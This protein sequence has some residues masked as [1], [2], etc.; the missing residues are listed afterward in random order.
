MIS[1]S[2]LL[3]HAQ[4]KEMPKTKVA[5]YFMPSPERQIRAI[6]DKSSQDKASKERAAET[7]EKK[8]ANQYTESTKDLATGISKDV[9]RTFEKSTKEIVGSLRSQQEQ[10]HKQGTLLKDILGQLDKT[11]RYQ[12]DRDNHVKP[13]IQDASWSDGGTNLPSALRKETPITGP[14]LFDGFGGFNG[15]GG[16]GGGRSGKRGGKNTRKPNVPMPIPTGGKQDKGNK[17]GEKGRGGNKGS[18]RN[19]SGKYSGPLP[20]PTAGTNDRDKT[21]KPTPSPGKVVKTPDGRYRDIKTGKFVK[22]PVSSWS[23]LRKVAAGALRAPGGIFGKG[24]ALAGGLFAAYELNDMFVDSNNEQRDK[25]YEKDIPESTTDGKYNESDIDLSASV[26]GVEPTN[27]A[28]PSPNLDQDINLP[29]VGDISKEKAAVGAAGAGLAGAALLAR[30]QSKPETITNNT[31]TNNNNSIKEIVTSKEAEKARRKELKTAYK[32]LDKTGT[33]VS[34]TDVINKVQEMQKQSPASKPKVGPKVTSTKPIPKTSGKLVPGIGGALT[35][36]MAAPD[37]YDTLTDDEV[38]TKDKANVVSQTAGGIAG[39][40]LGA[41]AGAAIG[42][43]IVPVVGTAIGGVAGGIIGGIAG[44]NVAGSAADF[45]SDKLDE[46]DLSDSIGKAVAVPMSLFSDDAKRAL[47]SDMDKTTTEV[48]KSVSDIKDTASEKLK[49]FDMSEI[50][51]GVVESVGNAASGLHTAFSSG[52]SFFGGSSSSS[53]PTPVSSQHVPAQLSASSVVGLKNRDV[54]LKQM[55]TAGIKDPKERAMFLA[56]MD[57]ESGG[58]RSME[59]SFNY[60]D[61]DRLRQVSSKARDMSQDELNSVVSKGPEAVAEMMYGGRMGNTEQ[62]DAYKYRGRGMIQ[63]TGKDNYAK[64]GNALGIDL[65]NNPDLAANPEVAAQIATWYWKD[66]GIADNAQQGDVK[67]VTKT[68][69][70]GYNGLDD[71]ESKYE[72]YLAMNLQS[73][74]NTT[75]S[76]TSS[77]YVAKAPAMDDDF[78]ANVN[79]ISSKGTHGLNVPVSQG[80]AGSPTSVAVSTSASTP[81]K[82]AQQSIAYG[83]ANAASV[84]AASP[85]VQSAYDFPTKLGET[86]QDV[87]TSPT[88]TSNYNTSRSTS[89]NV[90]VAA[91]TPLENVPRQQ[92]ES[93]K[94]VQTADT[95]AAKSESR[96]APVTQQTAGIG[97]SYKPKIDDVPTIISDHGLVL[98]NTGL[99]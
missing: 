31:T 88:Y 74:S 44:S 22:P 94:T 40:E 93:V 12:R 82:N 92:Y 86:A 95:G 14:G 41:S 58:F 32:E 36:A 26:D 73:P 60:K 65:V 53:G 25:F 35:L 30:S 75:V 23:K 55:D 6:P 97:P 99:V 39:A 20:V 96:A 18:S 2:D 64:A 72:Q 42:T 48:S 29:V 4:Q 43:M 46:Y 66:R 28:I 33:K 8:L 47:A 57:H 84:Q 62:G 79:P 5:P 50:M 90:S 52:S 80:F 34:Q 16:R 63:L 11:F 54:L 69:N 17:K 68:I 91:A 71:R 83:V 3:G 51:K 45:I 76:N 81:V 87:A 85:V 98:I 24:A 70:G 56:Q 1:I 9:G 19:K 27:T 59:E 49:D 7:Q 77:Q 89:S 78:F 38:S 15:R 37:L 61:T 10:L 67:A 21:G 13:K